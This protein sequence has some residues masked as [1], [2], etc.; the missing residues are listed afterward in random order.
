MKFLLVDD[1][2]ASR[3]LLKDYMS[4]YGRCDLACD[5]GEA[6]EAVCRALGDDAP[7]DLVFLDIM[8]PGIDGHGALDAIRRL[9]RESGVRGSDGTKVIMTTALRDAEQCVRSFRE[10]CESY[11]TKPLKQDELIARVRTLLGDLPML[12]DSQRPD[13]APNHEQQTTP[14]Q[15]A[16]PT[17]QDN[18]R[19][20]IVD[21]DRVCREL[22]KAMIGPYGQCTFAYDGA[23]AV[24]AVRLALND[25]TPYDLITLDIMMPGMDGHEALT[26]IRQIEAEHGIHGSDGARVIMTTALRDSKHCIRSFKEG[27]ECYVTKPI[28]SDDLLG[29]MRELGLFETTHA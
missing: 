21:D 25:N 20:L 1:D 24:D 4:P 2:R 28:D 8:M 22:I 16:A 11:C 26:A 10:G 17:E 14:S 12:P 3:E 9:E 7:Y 6:I 5:G 23:E 29:K 19:Y 15:E 13:A 18:G 27:C